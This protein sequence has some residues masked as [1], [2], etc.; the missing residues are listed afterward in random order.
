MQ[1]E[2]LLAR[3]VFRD[4]FQLKALGQI[5][6]KLH[7]GELPGTANGVHQ[8]DVNLGAVERCLSGDGLVGQVAAGERIFER[9]NSQFPFVVATEEIAVIV[10]I[11]DAQFDVEL[12]KAKRLENGQS[13]INAA[14]NLVLNLLRS[15]KDMGIVLGKAA[16]A[17]QAVHHAGT[18]VAINR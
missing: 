1:H 16:D 14:D 8:L 17:H 3:A 11:P 12:V 6:I 10:R 7:R 13:K 18:L 2:R 5:E 15:A 9:P 4:I